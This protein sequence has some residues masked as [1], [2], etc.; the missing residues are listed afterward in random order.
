MHTLCILDGIWEGCPIAMDARA[1]VSDWSPL[2]RIGRALRS[3]CNLEDLERQLMDYIMEIV[4]AERGAIMLSGA[5][6]GEFTSIVGCDKR[7]GCD[8]SVEISRAIIDRALNEGTP[9]IS[10]N[11]DQD[12]V[13]GE[14][15]PAQIRAALAIP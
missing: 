5:T 12:R 3:T 6:G 2:V 9:V 4:P 13:P 7:V 10:G 8:R 15:G 14:G 1:A 11:A